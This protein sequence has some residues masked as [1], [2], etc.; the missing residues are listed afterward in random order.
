MNST[1]GALKIHQ[2]TPRV[3]SQYQ[4]FSRID[5][6]NIKRALDGAI[7]IGHNV[8]FDIETLRRE[9]R[10]HSVSFAPAEVVC[11]WKLFHDRFDGVDSTQAD[12]DSVATALG[13]PTRVKH[14]TH[15]AQDDAMLA[16]QVYTALTKLPSRA[17]DSST[18]ETSA[19]H[20]AHVQKNAARV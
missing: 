20:W 18:N 19:Y 8:K 6:L 15:D 9:C 4:K 1:A 5:A 10:V 14:V 12:L 3:L 13:L 16:L 17:I 11:T 7:V 2:L